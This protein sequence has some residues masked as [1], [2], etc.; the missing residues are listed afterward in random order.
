MKN[1]T[2]IELSGATLTL[3]ERPANYTNSYSRREY[4]KT[5]RLY[6]SVED[7]TIMDNLLNRTKRPYNVYKSLIRSSG[8]ERFVDIGSLRWSQH[9]GCT[10]NCSPGFVLEQHSVMIN[11]KP[12]MRWDARISF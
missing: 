7:E 2:D 10:C 6:V 3:F 1:R 11:D 9:A 5:P 4:Y 12:V 8:I